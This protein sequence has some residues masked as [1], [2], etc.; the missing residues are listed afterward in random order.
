[1]KSLPILLFL[2]L[3][4]PVFSQT[5]IISGQIVD[6]EN[7]NELAFASIGLKNRQ[8]G[9]ISN[10]RGY[11]DFIIP[12]DALSDTLLVNYIGYRTFQ[13]PLSDIKKE[14]IR[15]QLVPVINELEEVV[16]RP[17]S[18]KDYIERINSTIADNYS[19]VPFMTKAYYREKMKENNHYVRNEEAIFES[20]Y[21]GCNDTSRTQH[22]IVLWR[23]KDSVEDLQ[24]NNKW[25][26][27]QA[28]KQKKNT[29]KNAD[30]AEADESDDGYIDFGG[31]NT[32]LSFDFTKTKQTFLDSDNFNKYSYK[33]GEKSVYNGRKVIEIHFTT[34]KKI[35][36]THHHGYFLVDV[37]T[38]AIIYIESAGTY[39]IPILLRPLLL[40]YGVTVRKADYTLTVKYDFFNGKWYPKDLHGTVTVDMKRSH[41]FKPDSYLAY[42]MEQLF[43]V[44]EVTTVNVKPIPGNECYK[45]GKSMRKQVYHDGTTT[46]K[47]LN[48]VK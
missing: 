33:I 7:G 14:N 40:L 35:D 21:S 27:K 6:K 42:N 47:G 18:P 46:W 26:L 36:N 12:Q 9:T 48:I 15:I 20:Y 43:L 37:Q 3:A 39:V 38:Y 30:F 32:L 41:L 17:L 34:E 24:F 29:L 1:M 16:I 23:E 45:V 4:Y 10:E 11:F 13:N 2:F 8:I 5:I 44:N 31:P 28:D 25:F 22:K 19:P